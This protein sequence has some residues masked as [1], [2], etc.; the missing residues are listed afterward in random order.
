MFTLKNNKKIIGTAIATL[1]FAG[2][3]GGTVLAVQ[4][5]DI[6]KKDVL[7]TEK[8]ESN[9]SKASVEK[10]IKGNEATDISTITTPVKEKQAI[11]ISRGALETAFDIELKDAE[12][13]VQTEYF[14]KSNNKESY[15]GRS[16]WTIFWMRKQADPEKPAIKFHS[17]FVDAETGD[18]LSMSSQNIND[19]KATEELSDDAAKSMASTFVLS[20]KL[21]NGSAIKE[22]KAATLSKKVIDVE[23]KLDNGKSM[24]VLISCLTHKIISWQSHIVK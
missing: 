9:S 16:V 11:E 20:K 7:M 1:L 12:Y 19:V 8:V 5:S 10:T 22:I 15:E 13:S 24:T 4:N 21:N 6:V 17:T 23:M 18:V 14:D 3:I 2:S